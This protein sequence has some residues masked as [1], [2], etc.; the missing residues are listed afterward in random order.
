MILKDRIQIWL[1]SAA[2]LFSS[3]ST[4]FYLQHYPD[5][6]SDIFYKKVL[7]AEEILDDGVE[8]TYLNAVKLRTQY[9]YAFIVENADRLIDEDYNAGKALY[10]EALISF[11]KAIKL[12]RHAVKLRYP[13]LSSISDWIKSDIEFTKEDIPYL[14]W[15][16][17]AKGGAI[18]SSR[19]QSKWII[20]LPIVGYLLETALEIDPSWNYGALHSAMI[21]YS[22]ARTDIRGKNIEEARYHFRKSMVYSRRNDAGAIVSFAEN[23]CVSEQNKEEFEKFLHVVTRIDASKNKELTLGNII[24]RDRAHWLLS[25]KDELFY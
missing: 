2:L 4:G 16:A 20:Q 23:V 9:T 25:R 12:G 13:Q 10:G 14:Y 11:E 3:C 19:G 24:A 22:M 8:E 21:S 7:S 5:L 18:S 17:A 15:L 6:A 1:I